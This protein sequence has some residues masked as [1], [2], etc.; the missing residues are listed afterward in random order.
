M[1]L[2]KSKVLEEVERSKSI[3]KCFP[4]LRVIIGFGLLVSAAVAAQP[5]ASPARVNPEDFI[6]ETIDR[7]VAVLEDETFS[8]PDK[9]SERRKEL[10]SIMLDAADMERIA[11]LALGPF[12][13]RFSPAQFKKFTEIFSKIL[14]ATY[15]EHLEQ[16][17][18]QKITIDRVLEVSDLRVKVET[19]TITDDQETPVTFSM[20]RDDGEWHV[21]DIRVEGVSLVKNY[22]SQFREILLHAS[23]ETFLEKLRRKQDKLEAE[24]E[25]QDATGSREAADDE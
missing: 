16:Y 6:Q 12:R 17:S 9:T 5:K 24:L 18:G 15:I 22:R 13:N 20:F 21:Y 8:R 10:R 23:P 4:A 1:L 2:E 3:M 25:E 19:L 7:V 14:F 11:M